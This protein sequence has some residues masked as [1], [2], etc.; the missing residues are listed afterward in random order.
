ME[1]QANIRQ[2]KFWFWAFVFNASV[3]LAL[4]TAVYAIAFLPFIALFISVYYR[5]LDIL[6]Y[7]LLLSI[8]FSFEFAITD[9]L[10]TDL[11]DEPLMWLSAFGTL[12]LLASGGFKYT[13]QTAKHPITLLLF[14]ALVWA[15][16]TVSFSQLPLLSVKWLLAKGWYLLCFF[17]LP[18]FLFSNF[19]TLSYAAKI[20]SAAMLLVTA[21]IFIRH[22]FLG[23]SFATIN[24][25]VKPFFRNHVTYS[26]LLVCMLPLVWIF[27]KNVSGYMK[28]LVL[29]LF[30]FIL[31]ALYFSYARGAW[32]AAALGYITVV[33]IRKQKMI[34]VIVLALL[35][36]I[37]SIL[38]LTQQK[39][40]L[41]FSHSYTNTIYHDNFQQHLVATYKGND[42]STAERFN[43]WVAGLRMIAD[44]PMN[45]Y[46]PNTFY[47]FYKPYT[48]PPF[49][50]WVSKNEERSTVHNYFLLLAIEQ[51]IPGLLLFLLLIIYS[52]IRLQAI[53][54]R[55]A[56]A[57]IKQISLSL[58]AIL[59]MIITV[60]F[61]S[62]LIETD[63]IGSLFYMCLAAI[64]VLDNSGLKNVNAK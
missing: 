52:F 46:G 62:D 41:R 13:I 28:P 3:F 22:A 19:K 43:R 34:P 58:A 7:C 17:I 51:G 25:A 26:A 5:R 48:L 63:K 11:P 2:A 61:L 33:I 14:A 37:I 55:A 8:P 4:Y 24:E 1:W 30:V 39:N 9:T 64:V 47:Y 56:S 59:S 12:L 40:Y 35:S 16:V 32:L 18:L 21:I 15:L 10:S 57:I 27:Y 45:G 44:K 38:F 36:L 31:V 49:K 50:T 29:S 20:L 53:Y 23:F 54:I 6:F 60:N 42:V